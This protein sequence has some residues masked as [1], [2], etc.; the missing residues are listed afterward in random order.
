MR[1]ILLF[2]T[3]FIACYSCHSANNSNLTFEELC[4][5]NKAQVDLIQTLHCRVVKESNLTFS[6][7]KTSSTKRE[8]EFW[9]V[10]GQVK[11]KISDAK[12]NQEYTWKNSVLKGF[13]TTFEPGTN[14]PLYS[15]QSSSTPTRHFSIQDPFIVGLLVV[16][17]PESVNG[18]PLSQILN[19]SVIVKKIEKITEAEGTYILLTLNFKP[20]GEIGRKDDWTVDLY[21]DPSV[22]YLIKKAV[23]THNKTGFRRIEEVAS[24]K[25][26]ANGV[27]FPESILNRAFNG[28]R[29]VRSTVT[30]FTNVKINDEISSDIFNIPYQHGVLFFDNINRTTYHIDEYGAPVTEP[31]QQGRKE[32]PPPSDNTINSVVKYPTQSETISYTWWI[33]PISSLLALLCLILIYLQKKEMS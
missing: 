2:L 24:F 18:T 33:F 25:E 20:N 12:F 27:F 17:P 6:N 29:L 7:G 16:N 10:P 26:H 23:Y 28:T 9:F 8:G 11:A 31:I 21:F 22:N 30:K 15:A 32:I 13:S 5:R 3:K 14:K 1:F 19:Q 4:I